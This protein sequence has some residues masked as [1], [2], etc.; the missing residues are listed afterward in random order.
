MRGQQG[1]RRLPIGPAP[2]AAGTVALLADCTSGA[3]SPDGVLR[4]SERGLA[5]G[6]FGSCMRGAGRARFL[7]T[8][9]EAP[10]DQDDRLAEQ[11]I[12]DGPWVHEGLLS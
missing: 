2:N 8:R 4:W 7:G 1:S 6:R 3:T 9:Q 12:G 11:V 5:N 10:V